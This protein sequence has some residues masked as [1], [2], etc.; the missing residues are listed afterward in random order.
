MNNLGVVLTV[1][2]MNSKL[3]CL[4]HQ[5]C[6]ELMVEKD[7]MHLGASG[8]VFE[9]AQLLR[10]TL[11]KSERLLWNRLSRNQLGV[12]FRRQHPVLNYVADFYCHSAKLI[13]E[14]DGSVHEAP[15]QQF[16][17]QV[18]TEALSAHGIKVIRFRNEDV[19]LSIDQVVEKIRI[20]LDPPAK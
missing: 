7:R 6:S 2:M 5:D 1:F 14:L 17:D 4:V 10:G 19:I 20:H 15:E 18:R 13:I 11:T 16:H 9:H 8:R 12:K 3:A